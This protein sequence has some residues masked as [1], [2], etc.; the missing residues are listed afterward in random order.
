MEKI[1]DNLKN[2]NIDIYLDS[3]DLEIIKRYSAYENVKGFTSNPSLMSKS[4]IK[5]YEEFIKTFLL[6]SNNKPVSFEVTSDSINE[7]EAQAKK[8]CNF[9]NSIYVSST[10]NIS[11]P[12]SF[13]VLTTKSPMD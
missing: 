7:M 3:A 11:I 1:L 4:G 5:S 13:T 9:S 6:I 2:I 8:I 12:Y 10:I